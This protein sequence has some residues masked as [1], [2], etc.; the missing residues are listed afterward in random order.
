MKEHVITGSVLSLEEVNCA[1]ESDE[2]VIFV[3]FRISRFSHFPYYRA[4]P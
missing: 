2:K 3:S 1:M 4:Y